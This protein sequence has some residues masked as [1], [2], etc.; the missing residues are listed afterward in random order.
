MD[1]PGDF[2]G[3]NM[4]KSSTKISWDEPARSTKKK[5]TRGVEGFGPSMP[6]PIYTN[7]VVPQVGIAFSWCK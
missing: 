2:N 3:I 4:C 6:V 1:N 5:N 7:K